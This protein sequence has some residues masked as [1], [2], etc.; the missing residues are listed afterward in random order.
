MRNE[1]L[2]FADVINSN[3]R[4]IKQVNKTRVLC[5]LVRFDVNS[6]SSAFLRDNCLSL[7]EG[8]THKW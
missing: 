5:V 1:I 3:L 7:H 4:S 8:R 6:S 2:R